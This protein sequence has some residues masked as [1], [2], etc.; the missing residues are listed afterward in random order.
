MEFQNRKRSTWLNFASLILLCVVLLFLGLGTAYARYEANWEDVL[1]MEYEAKSDQIYL[2]SVPKT[3]PITEE[4]AQKNANVMRFILS[5]GVSSEEYCDY[6]QTAAI[7]LFATAGLKDVENIVITLTDGA[8]TYKASCYEV[9][10][11][12]PLYSQYG[13]GWMYRFYDEDG[14]EVSWHLSGLNHVSRKMSISVEGTTQF[15]TA[16]RIF[17][18]AKPGI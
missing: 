3:E 12:M 5:N 13:P 18:E 9:V 15:P 6:D 4:E 8:M 14:G 16:L 11:G 1:R 7:S 10:E 17:A 2:T